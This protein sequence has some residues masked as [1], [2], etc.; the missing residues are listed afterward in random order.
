[1]TSLD[2]RR[3]LRG[4]GTCMALPALE[5]LGAGPRAATGAR[6]VPLGF[7]YLPNSVNVDQ[8]EPR[9]CG[10]NL[11]LSQ[12]LEPLAPVQEHIQVLSGLK[13]DKARA[14]G[15]GGGDHARANTTFLTGAQ[16]RKTARADV[17]VGISVD[18][19]AADHAGNLTR[20]PSLELTCD[21]PRRA[22]S[23]DSGY[24]CTYQYNISWK[25]ETTPM[26]PER[27]PREAFDRLFSNRIRGE[28]AT[29]RAARDF[30]NK[31]IL[32]FVTEDTRNLRRYLGRTDQGKL[33]DYLDTVREIEKRIE[34]AEKFALQTPEMD[35]PRGVPDDYSEH[36]RL[37]YDIMAVA[38]Q[39]STTRISTFL[40][41]HD[42]N[43]RSF[44]E[45]GVKEGYHSLSHHQNN[46]NKLEQICKIS[47]FYVDQFSYFI[48][49]LA[50]T[51]DG[52]GSLLD[53][54]MIVF[55]GGI[56]D[57]NRHSHSDLPVVL[58]GRGGGYLTPG[59]R[60]VYKDDPMC[61]LYVSLLQGLGVETKR[62]GDSTGTLRGI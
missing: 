52:D 61:N 45:V 33:D 10:S 22:G 54:S 16:A 7:V 37:M 8:W 49:K 13:H 35:R 11:K 20:L 32:D 44:N 58:A 42:G 56:S 14:N 39:T 19:I 30:Y 50:D 31:S 55:G 2:R 23:C 26:T 46:E 57:P 51:P 47:Q 5:S 18:Q 53:N 60:Q 25:S 21:K 4:L 34:T 3:F 38:F 6:P 15:D 43:N 28:V 24:S 40:P 62:F 9:G 12:T 17:E 29:N 59:K 36:L 27:N 41:S 1:M 48:Q